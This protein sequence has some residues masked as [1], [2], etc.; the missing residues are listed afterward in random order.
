MIRNTAARRKMAP[1]Q[2]QERIRA[3]GDD[4]CMCR[5]VGSKSENKPCSVRK[6]NNILGSPRRALFDF[7]REPDA[8][9]VIMQSGQHEQ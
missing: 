9:P 6:R 1:Q 7:E 3:F 5:L 8:I 2:I 4:L